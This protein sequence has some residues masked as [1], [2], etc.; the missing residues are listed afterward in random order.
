M[1]QQDDGVN[2]VVDHKNPSPVP[3]G[4]ASGQRECMPEPHPS[5]PGTPSRN[6]IDACSK[7]L[8][9]CEGKVATEGNTERPDDSRVVRSDQ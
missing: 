1:G 8:A 4:N 7:Y 6:V 5:C 2:D 9:R 3:T